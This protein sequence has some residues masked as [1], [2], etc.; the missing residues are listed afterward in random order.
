MRRKEGRCWEKIFSTHPALLHSYLASASHL[1]SFAALL[2]LYPGF[3][4][5]YHRETPGFKSVVT[6]IEKGFKDLAA[7]A[8]P[9][10]RPVV[11]PSTRPSETML[12]L[13]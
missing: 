7:S 10:P 3:A 1:C 12:P 4:V 5:V 6:A 9:V 11:F 13:G 2:G 8:S